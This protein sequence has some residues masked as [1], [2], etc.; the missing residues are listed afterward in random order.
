MKFLPEGRLIDTFENKNALRTPAALSEAMRQ[1]TI[2][3]SKVVLCDSE[4]NLVIDFGFMKGLI[5]REEGALGIREGT[6]RDIALLSKVNH[7]V[8]FIVKDFIHDAEGQLM[9]SLSRRAAQE[10]CMAEYISR[11]RPGDILDAKV[12]HIDPFGVFTDIGCGIPALLPIDAISISRIA[13]PSER[14]TCGMYIKAVV[15]SKEDGR[16]NL[17]HKEL[18]GTWAENASRFSSGETVPGIIR[19]VES[20]GIFV[21]LTPNLAGLAEIKDGIETGQQASV[22]IK[23]IIP[24]R[25]KIKLIIID[26]LPPEVVTPEKPRYYC[27]AAHIDRFAYSP[28]D[29]E[30]VIQSIFE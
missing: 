24:D 16:V 22:F 9:A 17:S 3:E 25:M 19:S 18:L 13:H 21:E 30:K 11:L 15:R 28:P 14:F 12:T 27:N 26:T 7:P 20:Y 4:H 29:C 1:G 10:I 5:P 23:S 8:C 6:V 2:L